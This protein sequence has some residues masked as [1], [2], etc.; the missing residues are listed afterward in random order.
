MKG[1]SAGFLLHMRAHRR[2]IFAM[3][4]CLG[5]FVPIFASPTA[6]GTTFANSVFQ[7][8]WQLGESLMT[9]FWGANLSPTS[10]RH[11]A[12]DQSPGGTRLV[13][14]F[15]KGRMEL[16]RP[17]STT[18]TNG[19]LTVE[20]LRGQLQTGDSTYENH[21]PANI[22]IAGDPTNAGPTFAMLQQKQ[23][24]LLNAGTSKMG[25]AVTR[26][27]T[28]SGANSTYPE[29]A[30]YPKAT[31]AAYDSATGHNVSSAFATF[32]AQV[33]VSMT[34]LAVSEPFWSTV[35]VGGVAKD[36]LIQAFER[37]VLTY[38]PDNPAAY[39]VEF[40]NIG[41]QYYAWRYGD[42]SSGTITATAA[43]TVTAPAKTAT[44]DTSGGC[45]SPSL[46]SVNAMSASITRNT[47]MVATATVVDGSGRICGDGTQVVIADT[48]TATTFDNGA[49]ATNGTAYVVV[50]VRSGVA[51][52]VFTY[53]GPSQDANPV[54]LG[55]YAITGNTD[56][57]NGVFGTL[58]VDPL[59]VPMIL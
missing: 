32:R 33:G 39:R 29:G 48:G 3:M 30:D 51:R 35:A 57:K 15:D 47:P 28:T 14:Y 19:L 11:E 24:A 26:A 4:A 12:Y 50:T 53:K 23:A 9:N 58:L 34:G 22:P 17:T 37:R 27:V 10:V 41:Q 36:V 46:A 52:A 7:E 44:R 55:V 6:A 25:A 43:A 20:L 45:T 18:V 5:S 56:L 38:T 13:Q 49:K 2:L 8:Q 59:Y 54:R 16:S 40:G 21:G 42:A 31:I 1:C